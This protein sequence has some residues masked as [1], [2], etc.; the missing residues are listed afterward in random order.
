M[1]GWLT[2][3]LLMGLPVIYFERLHRAVDWHRWNE[4]SATLDRLEQING[5]HFSKVPFTEIVRNRAKV[6]AGTGRLE[7]ALDTYRLCEGQPDCPDWLYKAHVAGLCATAGRFDESIE[8]TRRSLAEK[9]TSTMYVDL[10][11]QLLLRKADVC[12][13]RAALAEADQGPIVDLAQPF[14]HR[15]RGMMAYLEGD[16]PTARAELLAGLAL[17]EANPDQPFVDGATALTKAY[18]CRVF[19]KQGETTAARQ[20]LADARPYIEAAEESEI[21][22]DC[23]RVVEGK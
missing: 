18:L 16:L 1:V 23:E 3:V 9:A 22:E 5:I 4:V 8:W 7:D 12:A 2:F 17:L 11:H 14:L 13:A 6:L 20:M 10:A 15:C 19:A 21:L